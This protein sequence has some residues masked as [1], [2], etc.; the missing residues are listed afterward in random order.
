MR[1]ILSTIVLASMTLLPTGC[2]SSQ[3]EDA[4]K[5]DAEAE[6]NIM[7]DEGLEVIELKK[8]PL[9]CS[10][11]IL[12]A[13]WKQIGSIEVKRKTVLDY[14]HNTPIY[15]ISTDLDGDK[16]PEIL[17]RGEQPYA[18]IFTYAKDSLRLV[19]FVNHPQIG[20]S[21]TQDG[22][23]IRSG[24]NREGDY[25]VKFIKLKDSKIYVRGESRE[26]FSIQKNE[27]VSSGIEYLLQKDTAM[28]KVT[29]E[30][31]QKVAPVEAGT[32]I[33]DIEG[34]EDFRKP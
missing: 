13:A 23:I 17:L 28:V 33:E 11:E 27:V 12:S 19:T 14:R 22:A 3:A 29:K 7:T 10:K 15:F 32:Y 31:Y 9:P 25:L 26:T 21:I 5:K 24:S 6:E 34:W 20:I 8:M 30:E 16:C 2:G 18:A 1:K 4:E